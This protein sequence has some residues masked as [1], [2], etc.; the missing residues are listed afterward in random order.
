MVFLPL[1]CIAQEDMVN[2]FYHQFDVKE[3]KTSYRQYIANTNEAKQVLS[4]LF[5]FYKEFISSQDVDACVFTPSCSVYAMESVKTKGI[6]IGICSAFD[7]LSRCHGFAAGYY[8][9]HPQTH[10]YYDPV[11]KKE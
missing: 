3:N 5:L 7:R 2:T 8:P 1:L 11:E 10:K 4:A 9:V 6:F